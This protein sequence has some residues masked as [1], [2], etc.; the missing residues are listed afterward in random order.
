M[1]SQDDALGRTEQSAAALTDERTGPALT[2][3]YLEMA[4]LRVYGILAGCED[5]NDHDALR[6]AAVLKLIAG[7]SPTDRTPQ[8]ADLADPHEQSGLGRCMQSA[9][10][11]DQSVFG[12]G[13][14]G[15]APRA[16]ASDWIAWFM[17][18]T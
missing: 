7:R 9:R 16:R 18:P 2:H 14:R 1:H 11:P 15:W 17:S 8:T 5:Q 12:F 10:S 6:S 3:G 13:R 4:R